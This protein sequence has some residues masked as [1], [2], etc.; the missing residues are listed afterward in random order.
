M[1]RRR[2]PWAAGT[3]CDGSPRWYH[4]HQCASCAAVW[5]NS[6]HN[7]GKLQAHLCPACGA[8]ERCPF[9]VP[10]QPL[11]KHDQRH[12]DQRRRSRQGPAKR[13]NGL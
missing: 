7:H 6:R 5:R 1:K 2:P 3:A 9:S 8:K 4:E 12:Q 11:K 13:G 10:L